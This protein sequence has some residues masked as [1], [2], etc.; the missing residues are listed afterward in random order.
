MDTLADVV[1]ALPA[2]VFEPEGSSEFDPLVDEVDPREDVAA[3]P[4]E[5]VV[6]AP[7]DGELE[8]AVVL[9]PL[10]APVWLSLLLDLLEVLA[11]DVLEALNSDELDEAEVLAWETAD[12]FEFAVA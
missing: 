8:A 2:P 11:A 9:E 5:P 12:V 4:L 3:E 10:S 7:E 1:D 6:V